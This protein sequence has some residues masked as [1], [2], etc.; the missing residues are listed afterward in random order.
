MKFNLFRTPPLRVAPVATPSS[1]ASPAHA[2]TATSPGLAPEGLSARVPGRR[3]DDP[4]PA[5][6]RGVL[7]GLA[8][9]L[10]R[11]GYT[12]QALIPGTE[13][14]REA[15]WRSAPTPLPAADAPAQDPLVG[16]GQALARK[17]RD[18]QA[19]TLGTPPTM[20][21]RPGLSRHFARL[22]RLLPMLR[23][24]PM[25]RLTPTAIRAS[26]RPDAAAPQASTGLVARSLHARL[27]TLEA[28][29]AAAEQALHAAALQR[30][31]LRASQPDGLETA[32]A[33]AAWEA[34]HRNLQARTAQ[35]HT[36]LTVNESMDLS[37]RVRADMVAAA[38]L[39]F[40]RSE[41]ERFRRGAQA[42]HAG[43]LAEVQALA[44]QA[45]ELVDKSARLAPPP[46]VPPQAADGSSAAAQSAA[47]AVR[48]RQSLDRQILVARGEGAAVD[49][50]DGLEQRRQQ[51][52]AH[53]AFWQRELQAEHHEQPETWTRQAARALD[54]ALQAHVAVEQALQQAQDDQARIQARLRALPAAQH[55]ETGPEAAMADLERL[56]ALHARD[57]ERQTLQTAL[58]DARAQAGVWQQRLA[59]SQQALQELHDDFDRL[60]RRAGEARLG[61]DAAV[62]ALDTADAVHD[63]IAPRAAQAKRAH[64]ASSAA[65][66]RVEER[67]IQALAA[68]PPG[69][70]PEAAAVLGRALQQAAD[71][72][73]QDPAKDALPRLG[74]LQIATAALRDVT[75]GDPARAAA[76]L[77][78]L[79]TRH[80]LAASG[81]AAAAAGTTAGS[82]DPARADLVALFRHMSQAPRGTEVLALLGANQGAV[83]PPGHLLALRTFW[84]ADAEQAAAS[85]GDQA[86]LEGAKRAARAALRPGRSEAVSDLDRAAF[87]AVRN[88]MCSREPGSRYAVL[89]QRLEEAMAAWPERGIAGSAGV[90]P[91]AG[92]T[93]F[94]RSTL[95]F[96]QH[97]AEAFGLKTPRALADDTVR[98]A[99]DQ[100]AKA[101]TALAAAPLAAAPSVEQA[102]AAALL[103]HLQDLLRDDTVHPSD[104]A[105]GRHDLAAVRRRLE[106]QL[107]VKSRHGLLQRMHLSPR[108][109]TAVTQALQALAPL[110]STVPQVLEQVARAL[111]PP[112]RPMPDALAEVLQTLQGVPAQAPQTGALT[113]RQDLLDRLE[114][115]LDNLRHGQRL[116]LRH[117]GET[118]LGLPRVPYVPPM[119]ITATA[120]AQYR[121]RKEVQFEMFMSAI[122][123]QLSVGS[124]ATRGGSGGVEAGPRIKKGPFR[125]WG[126]AGLSGGRTRADVEAVNLRLQLKRGEES[127]SR[128]AA[129]EM[130]RE[131]VNWQPDSRTAQR[132]DLLSALLARHDNLSVQDVAQFSMVTSGLE[133]KL[134]GNATVGASAVGSVGPQAGLALTAE[135][136][137]EKRNDLGGYYRVVDSHASMAT[138]KLKA[139]GGL[140]QR[141]NLPGEHALHGGAHGSFA[142]P[143]VPLP[144]T[145]TRT[146]WQQSERMHVYPRIVDGKFDADHDRVYTSAT[147]ALAELSE[148]R[149]AWI[150]RALEVMPYVPEALKDTVGRELAERQIDQLMADIRHLKKTSEFATYTLTYSIRPQPQAQVDV[151]HAMQFFAERRGD[152]EELARQA[153]LRDQVMNQPA[154]WRPLHY[155]VKEKGQESLSLGLNF[156]VRDQYV[157]TAEAHGVP[158]RFPVLATGLPDDPTTRYSF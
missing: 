112:G 22:A 69:F 120:T 5:R 84:R 29:R 31:T 73:P 154:S 125:V 142:T 16:Q 89:N 91:Q 135:R 56:H 38:S 78:A 45:R 25:H 107:G 48:A 66:A 128:E 106:Q 98:R 158:N 70:A 32:Q 12:V 151:A 3:A 21:D 59:G 1:S 72:L 27:N 113:S 10:H 99:A 103:A 101:A 123:L 88:G 7:G 61:L 126:T 82:A 111:A 76:L 157:F 115:V 8:H 33:Q 44:G 118:G 109:A 34:A 92:S 134:Q 80:T 28:D 124:T 43:A 15:P 149:D 26:Q 132:P 108:S 95:A 139:S 17:L 42:L 50:L 147:A 11:Q 41:A 71:R 30:D 62:Q 150:A 67:Q 57:E 75:G 63:E 86:W 156:V 85:E 2:G 4:A 51:A 119:P 97:M 20:A 14:T 96:G 9:A 58:Q 133:F 74:V 83:L 81:W 110:G 116:T 54:S 155:I 35:L 129:K 36:A 152:A 144:V 37:A 127:R 117:G 47:L 140:V 18:L 6:R 40:A 130:L 39:D 131:M 143:T 64:Q 87:N 94:N 114:P 49:V 24:K 65:A 141:P 148:Q 137:T 19:R 79:S 60:A 100:L 104:R 13:Y 102:T 52:L 138:Q 53:E 93:P 105:L 68:H 145:V 122:S 153:A 23:P 136:L 146:M 90:N 77:Q 55:A 121:D 46:P